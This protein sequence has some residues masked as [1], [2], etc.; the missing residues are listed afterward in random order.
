VSPFYERVR[1]SFSRSPKRVAGL[2]LAERRRLLVFLDELRAQ[3]SGGE[4][5]D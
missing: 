1:F 2:S 3:G 4:A 5:A